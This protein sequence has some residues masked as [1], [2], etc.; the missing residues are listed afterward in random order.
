MQTVSSRVTLYVPCLNAER[1]IKSTLESVFSQTYPI[2]QVL[3]VDDGSIDQ[4]AKII[5]SFPIEIIHH[6]KTLGIT[7]T[8]NTAL[9]N[10]R[11]EFVASVDADVILEPDWLEKIMSN[12]SHIAALGGIGGRIIE[13]NTDPTLGQWISVHRNP[14]GGE[15]KKNPPCLPTSA[16]V[17]RKMALLEIGGFND[18]K[19]YDHSDLDASMRVVQIGYVLGYEP[20]AVCYHHFQGDIRSLFDGLWRFKKDAFVNCGL[21]ANRF[22]LQR[23]IKINLSEFCQKAFDDFNGGRHALVHLDV[24]GALRH[25]LMDIR[26]YRELHPEEGRAFSAETLQAI[27]AGIHYLLSGTKGLCRD[28]STSILRHVLDISMDT[29][30]EKTQGEDPEYPVDGD[31]ASYIACQFPEADFRCVSDWL[32]M[33]LGFLNS[34]PLEMWEAMNHCAE[35]NLKSHGEEGTA[36]TRA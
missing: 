8:R 5:E 2:S 19:R 4:T 16:V 23:K 25:S 18:D 10:A 31:L 14:D 36:A 28:L 34:L 11:E 3:V 13:T 21:F 27:K 29:A 6:P 22:G 33:F 24:I 35:Q 20:G 30:E 26:L 7:K 9:E 1:H 15:K 12:F 17:Y 32:V